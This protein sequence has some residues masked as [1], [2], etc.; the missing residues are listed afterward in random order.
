MGFWAAA[1][2]I[3]ASLL[4][5]LLG[6]G[7]KGSSSSSS[8]TFRMPRTQEGQI[9]LDMLME[10]LRPENVPKISEKYQ[11]NMRQYGADIEGLKSQISKPQINLGVGNW[12]LPIAPLG[13]IKTQATLIGGQA[14][15]EQQ[16]FNS[17]MDKLFDLAKS[18]ELGRTGTQSSSSGSQGG[19]G[20]VSGLSSA[21][22]AVKGGIDAYNALKLYGL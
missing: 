1:I 7:D 12:K 22:S 17:Y 11:T 16:I 8:S 9:L 5:G 4:G 18:L 15:M 10:S 13:A 3:A 14:E 2:P 21:G 20:F 19:G 6:G